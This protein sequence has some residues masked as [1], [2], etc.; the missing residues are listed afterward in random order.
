MAQATFS[1]LAP[2]SLYLLHPCPFATFEHPCSSHKRIHGSPLMCIPA[3][4]AFVHPCTSNC[5]ALIQDE[6]QERREDQIVHKFP[7]SSGRSPQN[8][9]WRFIRY[10]L[11]SYTR[12]G[13]APPC[14]LATLIPKG[15]SFG[16]T[17]VYIVLHIVPDF[18]R[19]SDFAFRSHC[20]SS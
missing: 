16:Y 9:L 10:F 2:A 18:H 7:W 6:R 8:R 19:F 14:A 11:N 15:I 12:S 1:A 17:F 13:R 5:Q 3:P 4:V 20:L